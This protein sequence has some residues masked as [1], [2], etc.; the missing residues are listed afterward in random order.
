MRPDAFIRCSGTPH[1]G[2]FYAVLQRLPRGLQNLH[3][4]ELRRR[5]SPE[6]RVLHA[7]IAGAAPRE[8]LRPQWREYA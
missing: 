1:R 7:W 4:L 6:I 2:K 3:S 8:A 5:S